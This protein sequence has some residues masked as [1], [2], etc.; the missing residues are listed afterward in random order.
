MSAAESN[1]AEIAHWRERR[2]FVPIVWIMSRETGR[3][4][5]LG[6]SLIAKQYPDEIGTNRQTLTPMSD[7]GVVQLRPH[8]C[9]DGRRR[10]G[11]GDSRACNVADLAART[12]RFTPSRVRRPFCAWRVEMAHCRPGPVRSARIAMI[13]GAVGIAVAAA[14]TSL[15]AGVLPPGITYAPYKTP[16]RPSN[17]IRGS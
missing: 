6:R 8:S 10:P 12:I 1:D 5:A 15:M 7:L 11:S 17:S 13:G 9:A 4:D 14:G 2:R 16:E 3:L